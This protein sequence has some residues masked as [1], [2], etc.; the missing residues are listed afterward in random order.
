MTAAVA[1]VCFVLGLVVGS[2]LN[3]VAWRIPRKESVVRPP[4][5]CPECGTPI[6]PRDNVPIVSWLLLRGRCRHCGTSIAARYPAVELA[7]GLLWAAVGI[8]FAEPAPGALPAFLVFTSALVAITAIDLEHY[9]I[10]NRVV[11]PAGF[12][13]VPLLALA[14]AVE[15]DWWALARAGIGA[16][17]AWA[18]F[19]VLHVISPRSMGFGDVRLSFLLGL[20]LGWLGGGE[21]AGGLFFGFLYGAVVGVA[22]IVAGR[23]KRR[24]HIPFGPFLAAGA[25]TFV[26]FGEP[27]LRAYRGN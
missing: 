19:F 11:Y 24:Q 25:M 21:V 12:L 7:T 20:H 16:V 22:L 3:V 8:R 15:D 18:F 10:P 14:S 9:I 6:S 27:L 17:G 2:F 5:H 4:S 26:L 13:A 23:R 1:G